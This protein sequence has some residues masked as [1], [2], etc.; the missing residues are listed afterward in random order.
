MG[1]EVP[2]KAVAPRM[3]AAARKGDTAAA[4]IW[5]ARARAANCEPD[6]LTYQALINAASKTRD[7]SR[8]QVAGGGCLGVQSTTRPKEAYRT[9]RH[10]RIEI[11]QIFSTI[12][13][14]GL[15]LRV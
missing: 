10:V 8:G 9:I 2:P 4:E 6:Q 1:R 15:N 11:I 5:F 14:M 12:L 7:G 13:C 3:L